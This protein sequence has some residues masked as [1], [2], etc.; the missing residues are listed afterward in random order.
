MYYWI[1]QFSETTGEV[2]EGEGNILI[3]T[4][5]QPA[6]TDHVTIHCHVVI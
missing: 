3:W 5:Y 2:V 1:L 4:D 6:H